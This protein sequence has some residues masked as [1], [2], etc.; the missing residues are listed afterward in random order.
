MNTAQVEIDETILME[1][2]REAMHKRQRYAGHREGGAKH[3]KERSIVCEFLHAQEANEGLCWIRT[4]QANPVRNATP[5]C[6][7][8][9]IQDGVVAY[10]VT[11][12]VDKEKIEL[13]E[14]NRRKS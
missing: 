11:E 9:N 8:M 4:V 6:F 1:R 2:I 10:E 13:I 3:V 7:G 14:L 12:L 5:D